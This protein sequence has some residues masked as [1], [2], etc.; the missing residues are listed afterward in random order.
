MPAP[1]DFY[2]D[3]SSPYGYI[4]STQIDALAAK[5]GRT[6]TWRPFLLGAAFKVTGAQ[7]LTL[8]PPI[9]STYFVHD[10]AR[11]ARMYGVPFNP[12]AKFPFLAVHASRAFYWLTDR[13]EEQARTFARAVFA[14][15][16]GEGRDVSGAEAVVAIGASV[17]I[18][19]AALHAAL[20]DA[21][22]KERLRSEVDAGL[23]R[24]V[25]GSPYFV[26]DG[27]A[28]WGAD[29]LPMVERWLQTGGW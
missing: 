23:A 2:F 14:A 16:F 29:R 17:G 25:F 6:V 10:F 21:A 11:S 8:Q 9:K 15:A 3:F 7:P 22:V 12:P 18:D 27:E 20:S 4:A 5:Y 19:S 1:I 24:N 13:A 28:F 26:I